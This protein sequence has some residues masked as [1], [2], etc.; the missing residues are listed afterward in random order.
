[1]IE[2]RTPAF[3]HEHEQEHQPRP[4]LLRENRGRVAVG[5]GGLAGSGKECLDVGGELGVMLEKEPL[6]RVRID[7]HLGLRDQAC[8]QVRVAGQDH[9]VAV[10][11]RGRRLATLGGDARTAEVR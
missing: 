1:M 3:L 4:R 9:R 2:A 5:T 8:E 11:V 7:L 10:A 6:R